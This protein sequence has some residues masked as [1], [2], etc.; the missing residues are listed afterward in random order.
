MW[1]ARSFAS[2]WNTSLR[3][4]KS[5]S[6]FSSTIV[7][8][9]P[10]WCR[11]MPTKPSEASRSALLAALA[12]PRSRSRAAALSMSPSVSVSAFLTSIIPA[13]VSARSCLMLSIVTAIFGCSPPFSVGCGFVCSCRFGFFGGCRFSG[14]GIFRFCRSFRGFCGVAIRGAVDACCLADGF[15]GRGVFT[16]GGRFVRS[17]GSFGRSCTRGSFH[18]FVSS[19]ALFVDEVGKAGRDELDGTD[20]VVVVGN[21]VFEQVW[22]AIRVGQGQYG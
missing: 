12:M 7:A 13:P 8:I 2:C 18:G 15:L 5:V 9:L 22:I 14:A 16:N 17:G 10:L 21:D 3:A 6:Q 19:V 20:R 11:Y 1:I 4:T